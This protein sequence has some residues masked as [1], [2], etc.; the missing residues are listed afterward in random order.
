M[1]M[2]AHFL[3]D[4]RPALT[5]VSQL[6]SP[7]LYYKYDIPSVHFLCMW[8][9]IREPGMNPLSHVSADGSMSLV[10]VHQPSGILLILLFLATS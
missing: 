10:V 9:I 6:L 2:F 3:F 8:G 7:T 5:L 4:V 1:F